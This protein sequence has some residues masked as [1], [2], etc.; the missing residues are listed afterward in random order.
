MY[1]RTATTPTVII[2]NECIAFFILNPYFSPP[3]I[4]YLHKNIMR[5]Q[6]KGI[7]CIE[8]HWGFDD[9][10]DRSSV[11]PIFDLLEKSGICGY[12]YHDCATREEFE[13]LVNKWKR[14]A[15]SDK[16][17]ILYLAFHGEEEYIYLNKNDKYSIQELSDLLAEKCFGKIIYFGSCST[18]KT[19]ERKLKTMLERTY[20]IATIGYKADMAWLQSTACDLFVFDALQQ[21]KL[22]SQGIEKIHERIKND[23]GNLHKL[24]ELRVVINDRQHFPRKRKK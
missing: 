9:I 12:I 24:L 17:P 8:G 23:Y 2:K 3:R 14:K 7:Y 20:A 10:R 11:L 15:V 18:L 16:Y 1:E 13:F 19:D 22:D 21:D 4:V 5:N 6:S